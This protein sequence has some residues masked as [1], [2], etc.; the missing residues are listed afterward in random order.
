[1]KILIA[2]E[3]SGVTREAF[4]AK[5]HTVWSCDK[6]PSEKP[7]NHVQKDVR[8]LL[9]KP[10]DMIIASP[11][12]DDFDLIKAIWN[13]DCE[14]IAIDSVPGNTTKILGKPTQVLN[15]WMFNLP[16]ITAA[17]LWLK[18]LPILAPITT[19][20]QQR[21]VIQSNRK[22]GNGDLKPDLRTTPVVARVMADTWG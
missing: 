2:C 6:E 12:L 3:F 10:W 5:G 21:P 22:K 1:M 7:G 14:R 19:S 16:T 15:P 11:P 8:E 17:A 9:H 13:A 4:A 18:N 20:R